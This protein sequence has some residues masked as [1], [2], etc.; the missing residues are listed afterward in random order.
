MNGQSKA[1]LKSFLQP[2]ITLP[3]VYPIRVFEREREG[4]VTVC[5]C[6]PICCPAP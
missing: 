1:S 3:N 4:A 6:I 5:Y 2:S